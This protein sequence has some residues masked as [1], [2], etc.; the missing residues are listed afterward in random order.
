MLVLKCWHLVLYVPRVLPRPGLCRLRHLMQ[1]LVFLC[2]ETL[3]LNHQSHL[4][5][6]SLRCG[7]VAE[8]GGRAVCCA[9]QVG[10]GSHYT[11]V[12]VHPQLGVQIAHWP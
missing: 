4:G 6:E 11:H 9:R 5:G 3:L 8:R 7:P 1:K 10:S 2:C 12:D